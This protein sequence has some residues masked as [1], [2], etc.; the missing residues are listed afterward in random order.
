MT[1]T[2]IPKHPSNRKIIEMLLLWGWALGKRRGQ[3]QEMI[4]APLGNTKGVTLAVAAASQHDANPTS[5]F[6]EIYQ[7]TTD[8]D[9][10]AFWEGPTDPQFWAS[11]VKQ[12]RDREKRRKDEIQADAL[13]KAAENAQRQ[14]MLERAA[15][16]RRE[17]LHVLPDVPVLPEPAKARKPR[18]EEPMPTPKPS[19][20][21]IY[22]DPD[23]VK[24]RSTDVFNVLVTNDRPMNTA[25]IVKEMGLE[26]TVT[27]IRDVNNRC[28]YLANKQLAVRVLN[29][30]YRATS[31]G[32]TIAA[33][34]QH[35]VSSLE[36]EQP[37]AAPP[38]QV[39]VSQVVE[40]ID[41]VIEA[42]LDLLLPQGFRAADLRYIAPW[43]D[44]TKAMITQVNGHQEG[45]TE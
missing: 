43:V 8:G 28:V 10:E 2:A 9:A 19:D 40:S 36:H 32:H 14:A 42:V 41:D 11:V 35:D 26:P 15:N 45:R 4:G 18:K 38:P 31:Q 6:L 7:L 16:R 44:S 17:R 24:V 13:A 21:L 33:R 1:E 5:V 30:T 37:R 3:M 22:V 20:R 39:A 29:G 27:N 12:A 23:K 34:I 25:A